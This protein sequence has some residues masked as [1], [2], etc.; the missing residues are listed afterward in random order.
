MD[1]SKSIGRKSNRIPWRGAVTFYHITEK[2]AN[3]KGKRVFNSILSKGMRV[4]CAPAIRIEGASLYEGEI[5]IVIN[6]LAFSILSK[7]V[8]SMFII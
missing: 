5:V 7:C 2:P 8:Q 6:Y 3:H 4:K 1:E